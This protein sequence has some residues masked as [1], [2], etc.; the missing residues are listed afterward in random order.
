MPSGTFESANV[1][2]V[3]VT[4]TRKYIE[5][6]VRLIQCAN[7]EFVF[8]GQADKKQ[9][10]ESKGSVINVYLDKVS[11][12]ILAKLEKL[13]VALGSFTEI[14]RGVGV[15]HKRVGH[16]KELIAED[17]YQSVF[18]KDET[19][20]PYLRGRNLAPWLLTWNDDSFISYG[21]WLAEPREP[22]YFEGSRIVL[23]QIP[24]QRLVATYVDSQFITDQSVF[25][26]KFNLHSKFNPKAVLCIL[27]S[28]VMAYYFRLKYSEFD[29]LFP[30]VKLQHFKD[31]PIAKSVADN[32]SVLVKLG[33]D[34]LSAAMDSSKLTVSLIS[35]L[36]S[37]FN[38]EK[39]SK[40]LQNWYE[41]EFGDFLKELK[42]AKVQLSLSEEAEW[43]QYFN[44]QKQK[45]QALK[46]EINRVDAEI[47]RM[48]YE[49]YNLTEEEI[50]IVEQS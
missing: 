13:S 17:P 2:T 28:E 43:M 50:K 46:S 37:K 7:S 29:D 6:S 9:W 5:G 16:T 38:L 26:A 39:P 34:R 44:E 27:N 20:V 3:I 30:K 15:Y 11:S 36:Q 21:K 18:K 4:Y 25:I 35:L 49:L 48:V 33:D 40:K 8:S 22:K 23:R 45:A 1:D 19:F 47:D 41:L 10:L 14:A 24:A 32:S 42:K 12:K 31:F